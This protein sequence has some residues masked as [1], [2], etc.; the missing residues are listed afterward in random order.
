MNSKAHQIQFSKKTL[1]SFVGALS[2]SLLSHTTSAQIGSSSVQGMIASHL[3]PQPGVEVIAKNVDNGYTFRAVTQKDGTYS[4]KGLA[5]G[6]Y[7]IFLE[8]AAAKEPKAVVLKVGQSLALDF[9]I[10]KPLTNADKADE[11]LIIGSQL[12]IRSSGGEIGTNVSLEQ[13][14]KLPQNTRNFLAFADLAPGVQFTQATDGSTSIKG[15]AQSPSAI[16]VFI[17]GVGQKNYVL[18]GGVTGQDSSRGN[19]FPQ[20][21]IGEYKVI[22]QNYSAEY[23]QLSSAAIV[24]VT[25]SG[26]NEFHGGIFFDYTDEG[27]RKPRPSEEKNDNEK[28]ESTQKQFGFN[29]GGPIIQDK[30]HFFFAYEGK[31]NADPKDVIP[32]G[33]ASVQ[34]LP[35]A[36]QAQTGGRSADFK[37]DLYFGKLSYLISNE[38]KIEFTAKIRKETEL[39]GIGGVN[40]LSYGTD[41]K[42]DETRLDLSHN[43]RTDDWIN[44]AHLLYEDNSW[45]PRPHTIGNGFKYSN[46]GGQAILNIGGG[47]DFQDKGQ[48]GWGFQ[49]D[50]TYLAI[51]NHSIKTGIKYKS[52]ELHAKEQQP[53]NPQYE[54]NLQ[55]DKNAVVPF[56]VRWGAPL[57]GVGDGTAKADN[58][59]LGIY[60]QDEWAATENLT[61]NA[62]LRWDY[63]KSDSFLDYKT[64]AD[65][66]EGITQ[67]IG[68]AKS[69]L[70]IND[71]ISTGNNRDAFKD[72]WQPR[73]GF[74]YKFNDEHDITLFGGVGRAYDRNLFDNLQLE[75]TKATFP[76]YEALFVTG[77]PSHT[78]DASTCI[79]WDQKYL[80]R[81]GL[82]QLQTGNKGAGREVFMVNNHLKTPYSDQFSLGVRGNL[83]EDWN[84]ETSISRIESKDGFVWRLANRRDDGSFF[85]PGASWGSPWGY[86]IPGFGATII[87]DNGIATT[88]NSF[89]FKLEKPK[90]DSDWGLALAY[91]YTHPKTNREA[92]EIFALDYPTLDG[93]GMQPANKA[94]NHRLVVTSIVGLPMGVDFSA[95]LNLQTDRY[96][97]GQDCRAGWN[98]CK[99]D[100]FTPKG[101]FTYKQVDIAFS[102][103]IQTGGWVTDSTLT[104]RLDVLNLFNTF[105]YDGYESWFG[106]AGENLPENFGKHNDSL[107]GPTRTVK[108]GLGWNW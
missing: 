70:N 27:M 99:F 24:A 92:D 88:A 86:G 38:Q 104:L 74:S 66:L 11:I 81:E 58:M 51:Q 65:V 12:K 29:V 4:F 30:M 77:D 19:P 36:L 2:L 54:Y 67:W 40:A 69:D 71:Y 43:W 108:L 14:N 103:D 68:I 56:K 23:D 41:K 22:T 6:N 1:A 105:N 78:C 34:D 20:S 47:P 50:F 82:A 44:D 10:D 85:E 17:D 93:Y 100:T 87:G 32:E 80:T 5:P 55:Y 83:N 8:A 107:A 84:A 75:T 53:Y 31:N 7:Q 91:T 60:I 13:I 73:V 97:Y 21:A 3:Q 62:G 15:G 46:G 39:T 63:E 89:Y 59:Q 61:I 16:N 28:V 26:S 48:S 98:A 76:A 101:R 106:G 102:K 9:E 90:A 72:A 45:S 96:F 18:R 64:P 42:N 35:S 94:P 49:E 57:T 95:K 52:I 79:A 25:K 33:G 37:E